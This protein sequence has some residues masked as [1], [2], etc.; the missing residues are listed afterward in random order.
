MNRI[1]RNKK[2]IFNKKNILSASVKLSMF[3]CVHLWLILLLSCQPAPTD[4]RAF[5]PAETL[6]YLETGNLAK[7]LNAL[8]ENEIFTKLAASQKDFSA[9]ENVQFAVAVT[10]FETAEKQ[11]TDEQAILNFKPRFVAVADTHTWQF[12]TVSLVKNKLGEFVGGIYGGEVNL[13]ISDKNGGRWFE[14]TARDGRKAFAFVQNSLIFFG[15]DAAAVEK[16]LAVKRGENDSLLKNENFTGVYQSSDKSLAFGYVSSEGIAQIANIAAAKTAVETSESDAPRSFIARVLPQIA[17]KSIKEIMWTAR[18]TEQGIED[19]FQIRTSPEVSTVLKETI[20]PTKGNRMNLA[21][22]LPKDVYSATRYNLQNPLVSWRSL[23]LLA[24][25]QTD[26]LSGKILT[27]FAGSLFEPYGIA[28]AETFLSAVD[29]EILTVRFDAEGE[30]AVVLARV[31]D[32]ETV[33]KSIAGISLKKTPENVSGSVVWK[34][35][36]GENAA[37]FTKENVLILGNAEQVAKFLQARQSGQNLAKNYV[38][39]K[40]SESDAV[41]VTF[42]RD[43]VEKVIKV[44]GKK[45]TENLQ[46]AASFLTETKFND[47]GFERKTVSP[48]GFIG[49]ILEQFETGN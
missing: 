32:L 10:G 45:K 39:K 29:S 1:E 19:V 9:L 47:R 49:T 7:T 12:Q 15:N 36:E 11:V 42:G 2:K 40:F 28:D 26:E 43:S 44:L 4:L 23:F 35:E 27:V 41:A 46:A 8:T 31:K 21:E 14:W 30:N 6:V 34:S 13:E 25:K 17:Q 33:K 3:I 48:F 20:V 38:L 18:K 22:F 16:S 37:A 5:A 24:A